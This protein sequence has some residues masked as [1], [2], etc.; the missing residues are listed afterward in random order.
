MA[1]G[2]SALLLLLTGAGTPHRLLHE[3]A[4]APVPWGIADSGRPTSATAP[5]PRFEPTETVESAVSEGNRFRV[6]FTR[7]GPNAVPLADGDGNGVPDFVELVGRTYERVATFY[8]GLGFRLPPDDATTPGDNGGDGRFDVYLVDF[9]LR[10]DGAFRMETCLDGTTRCTGYM[11]QENDFTG[12]GY[13]SDQEAVEIL[14]SHEFFHAVQAAYRPDLGGIASEGT[15]V[16]ATERFEPALD[17]LEGFSHY[18]LELPDRSLLTDPS[19]PA[20]GFSYGAGLFFQFANER[21]GDALLVALLEESVR[22]PTVRWPLL[23]DT[24]LRRDFASSFDAAFT[25]FTAWNL[26]TGSRAT[27]GYG[28]ARA[29]GYAPLVTTASALP[30]L[31]SSMRVGGASSRIF[32]VAG[33]TSFVSATFEPEPGTDL[34]ALYLLVAAVTDDA[35]L[36]VVQVGG[37]EPLRAQVAAEDATRVVVAVVDSRPQGLGRYGQLCIAATGQDAGCAPVLPPPPDAGMDAGTEDAGTVDAG[38]GDA[39]TQDAGSADAGQPQ[40]PI[41]DP[42]DPSGAD[43]GCQAAG[44]PLSGALIALLLGGGLRRRQRRA[45]ADAPQRQT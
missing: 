19:G 29:E 4:V 12:Y 17:D 11:L 35:V 13:P 45:G 9:A 37:P 44:G 31:L 3:E 26:G 10:A 1:P 43:G 6:H 23:L 21:F 20:V 2:V 16:W 15:A 36:R 39:G 28:Y 33:G 5:A 22:Q 18:Y 25:Q 30:T 27:P 34:A 14:A 42:R 7:Q 38:T 32:E 40:K 24:C 8:A 41:D